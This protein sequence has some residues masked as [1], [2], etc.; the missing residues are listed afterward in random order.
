MGGK[1][2][3]PIGGY[4]PTSSNTS[5]SSSG[6]SSGTAT[7]SPNPY[8]AYTY[9]LGLQNALGIAATPYQPYE[10][11]MVAGFTPSQIAAQTGFQ[12]A[13]GMSTPYYTAAQDL[14]N[15]GLQ[16][17][18]NPMLPTASNYYWQGAE[19]AYNTMT[20]L[21]QQYY[22]QA[23][24]AASPQNYNVTPYMNPYQR[25]VVDATMRQLE[26]TEKQALGQNTQ[27][28][29]L[30]GSYGGSGQFLG[31]AEV[32]R[33]QA[34]SN[35]QTLAQLNAQNYLNAQGQYNEQQKQ[36]MQAAQAA[37]Q[38]LGSLG[39][40]NTALKT[41]ALQN[42]AQ[43]LG[44]LGSSQ[45]AQNIANIQNLAA[46]MGSLGTQAQQSYLQALAALQQSGATQQ[47]LQQQQL[48][49]AYQQFLQAKAYPYQQAS[50]LSGLASGLGPLLG[51]TTTQ[52]AT[53]SSTGTGAQLGMQP[54]QNQSGGGGLFGG[55]TSLLGLGMKAFM[56]GIK[57]G[58]R[59]TG[60]SEYAKGGAAQD[61]AEDGDFGSELS[62]SNPYSDVKTMGGG[63]LGSLV[64]Q[65]PYASKGGDY[66]TKSLKLARVIPPARQVAQD[67]L[68]SAI[69]EALSG[70]PD[71]NKAQAEYARQQ[72][73]APVSHEI[74]SSFFGAQ[75]PSRSGLGGLG[76]SRRSSRRE[77]SEDSDTET[78]STEKKGG[79]GSLLSSI[80]DTEDGS[81]FADGG[82]VYRDD[83]GAATTPQGLSPQE[84]QDYVENLY[85]TQLGRQGE[86]GGM[87]Y[88]TNQ[89]Q[90]GLN[91]KEGVASLFASSPERQ[92]LPQTAANYIKDLYQTQLG[93]QGD[94]AGF[95][96]WTNRNQ[97]GLDTR[98]DIAKQFA[99][100]PESKGQIE[101]LYRTI[102]NRE[103]DAAGVAGWQDKLGSGMSLADVTKSFRAAPEFA[104]AQNAQNQ[105]TTMFQAALGRDPNA[106]E[107]KQWTESLNAGTPLSDLSK[108]LSGT[109]AAQSK[110]ADIFQQNLGQGPDVPTRDKWT[111]L[112]SQG[113]PLNS[114]EDYVKSTPEAREYIR[115]H[116]GIVG[117]PARTS[118]KT[119][120]A[121]M[122]TPESQAFNKKLNPTGRSGAGFEA[123]MA[124]AYADSP[125]PQLSPT[126]QGLQGMPDQ[127]YYTKP[128]PNYL[129]QSSLV[130]YPGTVTGADGKPVQAPAGFLNISKTAADQ[131]PAA[132]VKNIYG[133]YTG[134]GP[135]DEQLSAA[136]NAIKAG[137]SRES[138]ETDLAKTTPAQNKA[139]LTQLYNKTFNRNPDEAGMQYWMNQLAQGV[140]ASE[141]ASIFAQSPERQS[142]SVVQGYMP[143]ILDTRINPS[144]GLANLS[145]VAPYKSQPVPYMN[146][147][148]N[149]G[150]VGRARGGSLSSRER[151]EIAA[152]AALQ[153]GASPKD[154][155]MM[156]AIAMPESGGNPYAHNPNAR[157]GD[158]SYGLW[159]VNML[160]RMGP[161]R[162]RQF[163]LS[164]NEELFDPVT[165]ARAALELMHGRGGLG[166]WSTYR[167]G[168]HRPY[169]SA[170]VDVVN[171]LVKDPSAMLTKIEAPAPLTLPTRGGELNRSSIMAQSPSAPAESTEKPKGLQISDLIDNL[172]KSQSAPAEG[173]EQQKLATAAPAPII[174]LSEPMKMSLP[175]GNLG[176][177]ND[178]KSYLDTVIAMN[179]RARGGRLHFANGGTDDESRDR[180]LREQLAGSAPQYDPEAGSNT[181]DRAAELGL[182][183]ASI[184]PAGRAI[185]PLQTAYKTGKGIINAIRNM[186]GLTG[187]EQP[188]AEP[189]FGALEYQPQAPRGRQPSP[190]GEPI[191]MGISVPRKGMSEFEATTEGMRRFPVPGKEI[192]Y[193]SSLRDPQGSRPMD[194]MERGR[195]GLNWNRWDVYE[196]NKAPAYY[197]KFGNV[198]APEVKYNGQSQ[199]PIPPLEANQNYYPGRIPGNDLRAGS[200]GRG[201]AAGRGFFS[202]KPEFTAAELGQELV[203]MGPRGMSVPPSRLPAGRS[204][205]P[206][207]ATGSRGG[208]GGEPP[209]YADYRDVSG[210][211]LTGPR[212]GGGSSLPPTGGGGNIMP[213]GGGGRP[214]RNFIT[215][216]G[217]AMDMPP[218]R[219][220]AIENEPGKQ[221]LP[222]MNVYGPKASKPAVPATKPKRM[223]T[224]ARKAPVDNRR[225][226]GD[227]RDVEPFE[228][229]PIGGFL[230]RITGDVKAARR[231]GNINSP[232]SPYAGD[233]FA[234]GG[235]AYRG[236][237]GF[238]DS[239]GNAFSTGLSNLRS[240]QSSPISEG[241]VTAGLGMMSS[242]QH[243]PLRAIGEGGLLGIEAYNAAKAR[244]KSLLDKSDEDQK[245]KDFMTTMER[246][247][248]PP[249]PK[250]RGGPARPAYATGGQPQ[251]E[252]FDPFEA[253][254]AVGDTI[255]AGLSSLG[256]TIGEALMPSASAQEA[257][258]R[259]SRRR[260]SPIADAL[261]TAGLG[262]MASP[263]H[264]PLRAIGEGGLRGI[265]AYETASERQRKED[266][267]GEQRQQHEEFD[268]RIFPTTTTPSTQQPEEEK[269]APQKPAAKKTSTAELA[270][271]LLS[272]ASIAGLETIP[273]TQPIVATDEPEATIQTASVTRPAG[274]VTTQPTESVEDILLRM[275]TIASVP[276]RDAYEKNKQK[277]ALDMLKLKLDI[278]KEAQKQEA[279]PAPVT[280]F[281]KA[282]ETRQAKD[283]STSV[284]KIYEDAA[285]AQDEV[286]KL[287]EI[288]DALKNRKIETG[289]VTAGA[290][291]KYHKN[292]AP[293]SEDAAEKARIESNLVT[294]GVKDMLSQFGG[295][296]STGVTDEDRRAIQK[297]SPGMDQTAEYNEDAIQTKINFMKRQEEKRD[298]IINE[299]LPSHD[300]QFKPDFNTEMEKWAQTRPKVVPERLRKMLPKDKS[301]EQTSAAKP[302][303]EVVKDGAT[304][305][306][307]S[308]GSVRD[309]KTNKL[310]RGPTGQ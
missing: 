109:S 238:L 15:Q 48:A 24:N 132:F 204:N 233:R 81:S 235:R 22:T 224:P 206:T 265:Q 66:A 236:E 156:A 222:D 293:F 171:N 166:N 199:R 269:A 274:S 250:H 256:D 89:L 21:A 14:Y 17:Q 185:K 246:L 125:G 102:Y 129:Q 262:A 133:R 180:F 117:D 200:A 239:L 98:E 179:Q 84:A 298:W 212:G 290:W 154:A 278:A 282:M 146:L 211:I 263:A 232:M 294:A 12:N 281:Q 208:G 79:F 67:R 54:Y 138:I 190:G 93:R 163:G 297:I 50:Y 75:E 35:A 68:I 141:I 182:N 158:N 229:D 186:R 85:K 301:S 231:P 247:L 170:A 243:D 172:I 19:N 184:I 6:T 8:A 202:G 40:Q 285:K 94:Q 197:D 304:L 115:T 280:P 192:Y 42:A 153:A 139:Y 174:S 92:L 70:T 210:N 287:E 309:K 225:Y 191:P 63:D 1:N 241:L 214:P 105:I 124:Q 121:L 104:S 168:S 26:Q 99:G 73:L 95:E 44:A 270:P 157:T 83:G 100:S 91:T 279:K 216:T 16:Y 128:L 244:Q 209:I 149:G 176:E 64:M 78:T 45:Q 253:I 43:G 140:P 181:F 227:W 134:A 58:G 97:R 120:N 65:Q 268:R 223:T 72:S 152:K 11:Q 77:E 46:G 271:E 62:Q 193:W 151:L 218:S 90:K 283:V 164:R 74:T 252:G 189:G 23:I 135:T 29:V 240:S 219:P 276:T 53:Q 60:R 57:D 308:D 36:Q 237:G 261:I 264:N 108:Q 284:D 187:A 169:Y 230:D 147:F 188:A 167:H 18:A 255:G 226:W 215:K 307:Y 51:A 103:P 260:E 4:Y 305:V 248:N 96:Y 266:L 201:P 106:A 242:P 272:P 207:L 86:Q 9:A 220:V 194:A 55:L 288:V 251:N 144:T 82:R 175:L 183:L 165:N 80:F 119:I 142:S 303:A 107:V 32:A 310:L 110:L 277:L 306:R 267:L 203:P 292:A 148:K 249:T 114:I 221:Q 275:Q 143:K 131:D 59:V 33:Q 296:L 258:P 173:A 61:D 76:E 116:P 3:S 47:N 160:G 145:Y 49:N 118:P 136:V 159:Q 87:D 217:T 31:R 2:T 28:S 30:R 122:E 299:Y 259:S 25:D 254:G 41:Q 162:R 69:S 137:T 300:G 291:H 20:P 56:P 111:A 286:P 127:S 101:N 52:N 112:M 205:L 198:A 130:S 88:W 150:R 289:T 196:P 37:A 39:Y 177:D 234:Y 13:V 213:P 27:Q 178:R 302:V 123:L 257:T 228:S 126:Q 195:T 10:G 273:P 113:T 71:P 7:Q 295:R 38:G 34:L 245:H 161:E 5:S 155:A